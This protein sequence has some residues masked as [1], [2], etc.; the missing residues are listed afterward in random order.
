MN[1]LLT[2]STAR[3]VAP[4]S[5]LFDFLAQQYGMFSSP[6]MKDVHDANL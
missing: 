5:F 2:H 6:N 1:T 3:W 4:A